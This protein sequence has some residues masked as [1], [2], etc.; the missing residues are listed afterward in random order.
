[1]SDF[2]NTPAFD[3]VQGGMLFP[4]RIYVLKDPRDGMVRYVGKTFKSIQKRLTQHVEDSFNIND[5]GF[6]SNKAVWIRRMYEEGF[7]PVIETIEICQE[8]WAER[9]MY[10]ISHYNGLGFSLTNMTEGGEFSAHHTI[11]N[12]Y[13]NP[14]LRK[15]DSIYGNITEADV[16]LKRLIDRR[17]REPKAKRAAEMVKRSLFTVDELR[18][19]P[20]AN[21]ILFWIYMR[22]EKFETARDVLRNIS[23]PPNMKEVEWIFDLL[24]DKEIVFKNSERTA[25]RTRVGYVHRDFYKKPD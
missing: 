24:M 1:M 8:N 7:M 14:F 2:L 3:S 20:I 11:K 22:E 18:N 4:T 9:E 16:K 17:G 5:K 12:G 6:K 15:P 19:N 21:E 10:W 13:K 25:G 23:N